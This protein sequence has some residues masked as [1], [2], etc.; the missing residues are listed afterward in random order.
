MPPTHPWLQLPM[1]I[2]SLRKTNFP[3]RHATC[4]T[5]GIAHSRGFGLMLE[6]QGLLRVREFQMAEIEHFL[7]PDEK[8]HPKFKTV[9][10]VMLPLLP[11]ANQMEGRPPIHKSIGE[12]VAEGM[13]G[14][15]Q[16]A[17]LD[18]ARTT[19]APPHFF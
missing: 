8:D 14:C 10:D 9:A 7:D 1:P 15:G 13:V 4:T 2:S 6:P 11:R 17:L 5:T 3:D 16:F 12:A 19:D 18:R